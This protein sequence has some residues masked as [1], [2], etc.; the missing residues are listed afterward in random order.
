MRRNQTD[1]SLVDSAMASGSKDTGK[2]QTPTAKRK[3]SLSR[4][5]P[6]FIYI[7]MLSVLLMGYTEFQLWQMSGIAEQ[8]QSHGIAAIASQ[9]NQTRPVRLRTKSAVVV[10][11]ET[12][13]SGSILHIIHSRFM[14]NQPNLLQ[15][16]EA[17]LH[18]FRRFFLAS[19]KQQ[20]SRNFCVIVR[21]DPQLDP[22]LKEG[23]IASLEDF[24]VTHVLVASNEI[25][26][27]QYQDVASDKIQPSDVWS[28][29][30]E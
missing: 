9:N 16:G 13:S 6:V 18:L 17:R 3:R 23:L 29:S 22:I 27:S 10:S 14:Q 25:P 8:S 19:L 30:L 21:T 15:L 12:S 4:S 24:N 11:N 26:K 2:T 7:V 28:G 1:P 5:L 20:S